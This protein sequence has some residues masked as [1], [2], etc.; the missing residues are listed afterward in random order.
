[1]NRESLDIQNTN[2][3][4]NIASIVQKH[5]EQPNG[6]RFLNYFF[7]VSDSYQ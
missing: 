7:S 6:L 1:M 5:G 4:K 3:Q 2:K